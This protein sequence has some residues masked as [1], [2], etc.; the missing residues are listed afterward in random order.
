MQT[1]GITISGKVQGVFFRKYTIEAA[2]KAGV[3]G[4][5]MNTVKGDVY[6]EATGTET[7]IAALIEWCHTGSPW[8]KVEKVS[9]D[10]IPFR[11]FQ[12]FSIRYH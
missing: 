9:V 12:G 3:S 5:V 11:Q 1:V 7:E 4:F 8:S 2:M 10:Q 6:I